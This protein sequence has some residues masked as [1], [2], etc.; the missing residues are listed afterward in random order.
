MTP[1][2]PLRV[3]QLPM[4]F[5]EGPED[6]DHFLPG[7]VLYHPPHALQ[8]GTALGTPPATCLGQLLSPPLLGVGWGCLRSGAAWRTADSPGGKLWFLGLGS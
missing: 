5:M 3:R 8:T 1:A 6:D 7:S 4:R 2:S